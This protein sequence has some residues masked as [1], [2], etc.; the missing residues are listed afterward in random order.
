MNDAAGSAAASAT[1]G[2][3][4]R[5]VVAATTAIVDDWHELAGQAERLGRSSLALIR[6]DLECE[7]DRLARRL[8]HTALLALLGALSAQ[9]LV[10]LIVAAVWNSAWRLPTIAGLALLAVLALLSVAIGF[11]RGRT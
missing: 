3:R 11:G 8:R 10:T 4:P 2:R 9:L 5:P 7:R 6:F 1:A